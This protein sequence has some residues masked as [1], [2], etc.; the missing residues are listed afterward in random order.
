M[1]TITEAATGHQTT[2]VYIGLNVVLP[3]GI[4]LGSTGLGIFGFRGIFGMHY[5]RN[6][7][8]GANTGVPAL[9]WLKAAGGQPHLLRGP[10]LSGPG[11]GQILWK[12]KIDHWAF[13]VGI[14]I[15]TMEGGYVINLDGTFLLELPGPRVLIMMN[16]RIVSP[17]PSV[18]E[19]GM[20][21]GIL[22]VIE[23][24]PEHFLIGILVTWEVESL[25]KIVIPIEAV[26]KHELSRVRQEPTYCGRAHARVRQ[27]R[28]L[29][30]A[31]TARRR[32]RAQTPGRTHVP[33]ASR[34]SDCGQIDACF[35]F[36]ETAKAPAAAPAPSP[37]Q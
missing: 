23:I 28:A 35:A 5:E 12:P 4:A 2:G 32:C 11:T 30:S 20:T 14:L 22:A 19:L 3:A 34:D 33:S 7:E 15:G 26:S 9:A 16:A 29:T 13:G 25:V 18:G 6:A 31:A 8:I 37:A 10:D 21:V 17:P 1:A 27:G 24:T 36:T